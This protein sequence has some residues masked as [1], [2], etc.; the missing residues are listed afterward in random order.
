[1][2][3]RIS[4]VIFTMALVLGASNIARPAPEKP[5]KPTTTR[6]KVTATAKSKANNKATKP[7]PA[8]HSASGSDLEV[9]RFELPPRTYHS[10]P[11][12]FK[13]AQTEAVLSDKRRAAVMLPKGASNIALKKPVTASD[14]APIIGT[15]AMITDGDKQASEGSWV[16]LGPGTQWV[17]VDLQK[18]ST[19]YGALLWHYHAEY[20][21]YRDIIVQVADNP[22][23]ITNV[24]TFYN[25]DRDNSSGLGKGADPE[26]Y[27]TFQGQ[28]I[29]FK[30]PVRAR[31]IR[32]YSRG[33]SSDPQN[34]YIEVEVW[35]ATPVKTIVSAKPKT[36]N[37]AFKAKPVANS[38]KN[39]HLEVAKFELPPRSYFHSHR[40]PPK[41]TAPEFSGK[42]RGPVLLPRGAKNIALHKPVT[43]SDDIPIIGTLEM[44][45]D[46]DKRWNEGSWVELGPGTQWVQID[47]QKVSTLYGALL[48][49]YHAETRIYRDVIVQ[50]ADNAYFTANVRT[51]YNNDE[52]NSS[53]LG[54]GT[55]R[56]F[57]ESH[58][59]QWIP[60]KQ[61][62]KARY[63][64]FYSKGNSSDPQN[65]YIEVEVWGACAAL[66]ETIAEFTFSCRRRT[67]RAWNRRT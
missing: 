45:T 62:L 9:A 52:N 58:E 10:G 67:R 56:E 2:K 18:V 17:Q 12:Q 15:L 19:L 32:F 42:L 34:Q 35:G 49:H 39:S 40:E 30:Q 31:Y 25:N 26:F 24:R 20:R 4:Q 16:E 21:V 57:Y 53:G 44:I 60:F 33:N 48:W 23:F 28:W 36:N 38:T 47:L 66:R 59:G 11:R 13:G 8:A 43:S 7:K 29:P 14:D 54:K 61:P 55:E 46:G 50:V 6:A 51:L 65:Q 3:S 27:D 37:P 1:M 64:R 5:T 41:T 63:I 22:D